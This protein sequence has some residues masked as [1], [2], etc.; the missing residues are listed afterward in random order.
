MLT[1]WLALDDCADVSVGPLE[2]VPGSHQWA[3]ATGHGTGT[4]RGAP[5]QFFG[6]KVRTRT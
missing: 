3:D 4:L 6:L 1:V 5:A 2:Y